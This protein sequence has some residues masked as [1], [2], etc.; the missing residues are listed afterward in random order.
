MSEDRRSTAS[1]DDLLRYEEEPRRPRRA[2]PRAVWAGK[3]LLQ[4]AAI[5][6]VVVLLARLLLVGLPVLLVFPAALALVLL[7]RVL[8]TVDVVPMDRQLPRAAGLTT[9]AQDGLFA[10]AARWET[11]LSWTQADPERFTRTVQAQI[12]ELVDERLR[13]RHSC[14][15]TSDPVRARELL[16]GPLWTFLT[17]PVTRTLTP[18][19]LADVVS[20]LEG[21]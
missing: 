3:V 7:N 15:M 16:G 4:A 19:E 21:L 17:T 13:Q 1:I 10:A 6:A 20:T 8:R 11:R 14:T 9:P 5:T 18:R 12:R 2:D